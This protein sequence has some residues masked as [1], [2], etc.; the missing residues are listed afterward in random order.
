MYVGYKK[1][2]TYFLTPTRKKIGKAVA[3]GSKCTV[4]RECFSDPTTRN[5]A[6][7]YLGTILRKEIKTMVSHNTNSI[8]HSPVS[9]MKCFTWDTLLDELKKYAPT[10]LH[11]LNSLT[12]TKSKRPNEKAVIGICAAILLKHRD[13][14]MSLIQKITSII[15][16]AGHTS[17]QVNIL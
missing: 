7:N 5:F 16:Y 12:K 11:L 14:T 10:F 9:S 4:A 8:L 2:K 6:L 1:P 13:P 17:K 15:L 3:R